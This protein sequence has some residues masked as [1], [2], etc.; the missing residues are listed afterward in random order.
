MSKRRAVMT[1]PQN[2]IRLEL[3]EVD[4]PPVGPSQTLVRVAAFS[5]N[6]GEVRRAMSAT[7]R[8]IPGWDLAGIVEKSAADGSGPQAGTRVVGYMPGGTWTELAAVQSNALAALPPE[9]SFSQAATLPVA[10]L[11]ALFALE[12]GGSLLGRRVLVT[13]ASGGVG[14]FAV[15]LAYRA[16]ASV[17]GITNHTEYVPMVRDCGAQDIVVG[18]PAAATSFGPYHLICDGVGGAHLSIVAGMLAPGGICVTYAAMLQ[19][20]ISVNLRAMVQSPGASLTGLLVLGELRNQP[21]SVGLSRLVSLVA[22][23][24]LHPHIAV[25][26]P[27]NKI[28]EVSQRLI[29]RQFSG[30]AVLLWN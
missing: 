12:K 18:D 3:A 23:G 21:A 25:E 17:V 9:V 8:Y 1:N 26:V 13:G 22:D 11:T 10:G 20:E 4:E 7:E 14:D 16:G 15:Q 6:R 29:D 28:A 27:A 5:L 30:K 2:G 24:R 19:P